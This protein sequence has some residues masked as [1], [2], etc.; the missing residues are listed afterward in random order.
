MMSEARR[1]PIRRYYT[2]DPV[3]G[4]A[5]LVIIGF[6]AIGAISLIGPQPWTVEGVAFFAVATVAS[7]GALWRTFRWGV[8]VDEAGVLVINFFKTVERIPWE[9]VE[10]FRI[11]RGPFVGIA[12]V[13]DRRSGERVWCSAIQHRHLS[14]IERAERKAAGRSVAALNSELTRRGV[15]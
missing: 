3:W 15:G 7:A 10:G 5:A 2:R 4:V 13:L 12:G 9:D 1:T 8:Y 11:D 6:L 14:S